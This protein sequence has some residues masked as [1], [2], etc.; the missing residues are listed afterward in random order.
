MKIAF[1]FVQKASD[2]IIS[3]VR[4]VRTASVTV[5]FRS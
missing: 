3:R 1:I 5:S 2:V 4:I